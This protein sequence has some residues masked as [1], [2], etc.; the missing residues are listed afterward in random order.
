ML[1][2]TA[3]TTDSEAWFSSINNWVEQNRSLPYILEIEQ[4][5]ISAL[6]EQ[7]QSFVAGLKTDV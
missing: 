7:W 3:S 1:S 2:L 6:H 4:G 5:H